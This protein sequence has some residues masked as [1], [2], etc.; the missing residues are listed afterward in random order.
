MFPSRS[1]APREERAV[2]KYKNIR[3]VGKGPLGKIKPNDSKLKTS[4]NY[5]QKMSYMLKASTLNMPLVVEQQPKDEHLV[6]LTSETP[7]ELKS[8]LISDPCWRGLL[9]DRITAYCDLKPFDALAGPEA[10]A[11]P[12]LGDVGSKLHKKLILIKKASKLSKAAVKFAYYYGQ[13]RLTAL[14][15]LNLLERIIIL[16]DDLMTGGTLVAVIGVIE[17]AGGVVI[18]IA[19]A[20][21]WPEFGGR[22]LLKGYEV[23]SSLKTFSSP[24]TAVK[25]WKKYGCI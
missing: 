2:K 11:Y 15:N 25:W 14:N 17:E 5:R 23:F 1:F 9:T 6:L 10:G 13:G 22:D 12:I 20:I 7:N 24:H 8:R 19:C 21:E 4:R 3:K 18:G 16:E